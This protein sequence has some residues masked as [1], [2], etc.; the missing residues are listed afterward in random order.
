M[1]ATSIE[2]LRREALIGGVSNTVFNG[3]IA[4]LLLADGAALKWS[5]DN[6]FV[7]DIFAT[8][9]LLPFIVALIV[10][11][12][13]R[14][15]YRSGALQAIDL[16]A[17]SQLQRIADHFPAGVFKAALCFGLTGVMLVAP[18]TLIGL[19]MTGIEQITPL[20][21]AIFKGIWA[22]AMA[23]LLVVPMVM[24]ALRKTQS[25]Q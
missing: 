6:S 25:S 2:H 5:G 17:D 24:V 21:Y 3:V 14:R 13:Q 15:Q 23:A 18:I 19:Y 22:G 16:G 8:A 9:L 11:P 1:S 12:L 20:Y 4:W 7:V 10:I